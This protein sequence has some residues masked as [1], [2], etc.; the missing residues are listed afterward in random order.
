MVVYWCMECAPLPATALIPLFAY[1]FTG[2]LMGKQVCGLYFKD[3]IVLFLG[4]LTL[5]IAIEGKFNDIFLI[6]LGQR[7][8][9]NKN[10]SVWNLHKRIA[11]FVLNKVGT[12]PP[13]LLAGFMGT[14]SFISMWMS[15]VASTA[16]MAP[17][18]SDTIL[19]WIG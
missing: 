8:I 12:K 13:L 7:A 1:P 14:T 9:A 6:S 16:M 5:A 17:I 18:G 11:L 2:V 19:S 3:V 10:I 15:N 4:G